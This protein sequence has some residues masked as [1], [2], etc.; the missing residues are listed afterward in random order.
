VCGAALL[1]G[2]VASP[3]AGLAW[4]LALAAVGT[5]WRTVTAGLGPKGPRLTSP[6]GVGEGY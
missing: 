5:P 6:T 3:L 4:A 2:F 1:A